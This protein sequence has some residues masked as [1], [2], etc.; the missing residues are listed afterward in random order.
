[1]ERYTSNGLAYNKQWKVLLEKLLRSQ[2]NICNIFLLIRSKKNTNAEDRVTQH[3]FDQPL[4]EVLKASNPNFMRKIIVVPGDLLKPQLGISDHDVRILKNTINIVYHC[5]ASLRMNA[6]LKENVNCNVTTVMQ[7]LELCREMRHL[8]SVVIVSTTYSHSPYPLIPEAINKSDFQPDLILKMCD[9]MDDKTL[10][11]ITPVLLNGH[12]DTY[13]FSKLLMENMLLNHTDLPIVLFRPAI[14]TPSLR[15]PIYGWVDTFSG[16]AGLGFAIGSG[17]LR[18]LC[19]Q[20]NA[21]ANLVPVDMCASALICSAW[22]GTRQ[23]QRDKIAVYNYACDKHKST[24]QVLALAMYGSQLKLNCSIWKQC[25]I[26]TQYKTIYNLSR[27]CLER[28]PAFFSDIYLKFSGSKLRLQK[29][30]NEK[31][32]PFIDVLSFYFS[33]GWEMEEG[34]TDAMWNCLTKSEKEKYFFDTN[35]L[36]LNELADATCFGIKVYLAKEKI[37]DNYKAVRKQQIFTIA[38]YT[39]IF[40]IIGGIVWLLCTIGRCFY[41]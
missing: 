40:L 3:I 38:H 5:A 16:V 13:T 15:E 11:E 23:T 2:D 27:L 4:F 6:T 21:M 19:L 30:Y 36:D 17:F 39:L 20:N 32:H 22:H 29:I 12:S 37:E 26:I 8:K 24:V 9:E 28:I 41:E 33:N 34:N 31:L 10:R 7:L 35:S 18:S 1:M 25:V 14:V